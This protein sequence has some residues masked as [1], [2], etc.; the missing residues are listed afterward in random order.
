MCRYQ[1]E[2]GVPKTVCH[3]HASQPLF[4]SSHTQGMNFIV[5]LLLHN[6]G[7]RQAFAVLLALMKENRCIQSPSDEKESGRRDGANPASAA[8]NS[9]VGPGYGMR[10]LFTPEMPLLHIRFFQLREL[11]KV[12]KMYI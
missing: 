2:H 5:G 8:I 12:R 3:A 7:P 4:W 10:N 6:M 9:L 11:M 1:C